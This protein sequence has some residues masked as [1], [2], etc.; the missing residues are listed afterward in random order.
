MNPTATVNIKCS[1]WGAP[2]DN[3][4][5]LNGGQCRRNFEVAIAGSNGY[6]TSSHQMILG[7]HAPTFLGTAA[8]N[9][10]V[11]C[12]GKDTYMGHKLFN[13]GPF[14]PRLCSAACDA[15]SAY[16]LRHPPTDG[17]TPK[18]CRFFNTYIL[19]KNGVGQGQYCS[20]YTQAWSQ[21]YATNKGQT[22]GSDKYTISY[23][24]AYTNS[25]DDGTSVCSGDGPFCSSFIN[26]L[27]STSTV[28]V[29]STLA[30]AVTTQVVT[31]VNTT[32]V[33]TATVTVTA[34]GMRMK[35]QELTH[36]EHSIAIQTHDVIAAGKPTPPP[37]RLARHRRALPT[38]SNLSGLSASGVS[39]LCSSIA[40]GV[41]TLTSTSTATVALSTVITNEFSTTTIYTA[42]TFTI[43]AV[44]L[45]SPTAIV[46]SLNGS[47]GNYDDSF[48]SLTLPFPI[49]GF[50]TY[51]TQVYLMING[52]VSLVDG[53]STYTNTDLPSSAIPD[54]TLLGFW[55]DLYIYAGTQQ[56][57]YY[58]IEGAVGN[59][60]LLFEFYTSAYQR[61]T[62]YFHFTMGFFEA[63]PGVAVYKYYD[64]S[65]NGNSS[66]VGAQ[67]RSGELYSLSKPCW[68]H[69]LLC[70][71][72]S[73]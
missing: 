67:K 19:N 28:V 8:V 51:S 49:G 34:Q 9:A 17:S 21:V 47:P 6:T 53:T 16:N 70:D 4:T 46:G 2:I 59:R 72:T 41:V 7:Y 1:Y 58:Q 36:A 23:S 43:P 24:F 29:T 45:S 44:I 31:S 22:R 12:N 33:Y 42:S 57:I 61:P 65:F 5:A 13:D 14:D 10:P 62:E 66:T 26:Y 11:D 35:R 60:S 55:D 3:T 38:P 20:L 18:I 56:G 50:G 37:A 71:F 25:T 69:G 63:R 27:P 32:T 64:I 52:M 54:I 39:S 40:T 15:Q 30:P 73:C 68:I 48:Y